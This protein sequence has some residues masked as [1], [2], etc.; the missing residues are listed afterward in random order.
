MNTLLVRLH[1]EESLDLAQ[2]EVLAVTQSNELIESAEKLKSIAQNLS[3]I[4]ASADAGNNLGEE[5]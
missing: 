5:V 2:S 1:V 4:Q 3:L